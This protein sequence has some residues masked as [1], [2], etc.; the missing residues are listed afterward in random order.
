MAIDV[1]AFAKAIRISVQNPTGTALADATRLLAYCNAAIDRH[2]PG[3]DDAIKDMA[4][5]QLGQ[6]LYDAPV[7]ERARPVT[8]LA[9]SGV[10]AMLAPYRAHRIGIDVDAVVA[11]MPEASGVTREMV[12]SIINATLEGDTFLSAEM[13]RTDIRIHSVVVPWAIEGNSDPLP[14]SKLVNAPTGGMGGGLTAQQVTALIDG[15]VRIVELEEFESALRTSANIIREH[16]I[17]V[18]IAEAAYLLAGNPTWPAAG[19]DREIVAQ[20]RESTTSNN[21]SASFDLATLLRLPAASPAQ[22]LSSSNAIVHTEGGEDYYFARTASNQILFSAGS[23]G[24]YYLTINDREIDL[25]AFARKSSSDDVPDSKIPATIAR[26]SQLGSAVTTLAA[27]AITVDATGFDG[28]LATTD[29]D[30]QK[31]AQKVDDLVLGSSGGGGLDQAAV[32]ARVTAL[33]PSWARS[34]QRFT[35]EQQDVFD[36]FTGDDAW[37]DASSM[38]GKALYPSSNGLTDANID[39]FIINSLLGGDRDAT[40]TTGVSATF[41]QGTAADNVR[42]LV[43]VTDADE[44]AKIAN[45]ELRVVM[46]DSTGAVTRSFTSDTWTTITRHLRGSGRWWYTPE[47]SYA[48]AEVIKVEEYEPLML[49]PARIENFYVPA[50]WARTGN[51]DAIPGSKLGNVRALQQYVTERLDSLRGI[52]IGS[53]TTNTRGALTLFTDP[54]TLASTDH[55]LLL[56]GI[57]WQVALASDGVLA[58]DDDAT[59]ERN[60]AFHEITASD[61]Y[62]A[63]ALNGIKVGEVDVWNVTNA[64]RGTTK[65]GTVS[66]WIAKNAAGNVGFYFD[67]DAD[68]GGVSASGSIQANIEIFSIP[69]GAPAAAASGGG[70]AW[71]RTQIFSGQIA[72][73][74]NFGSADVVT[75][76]VSAL[77][78]DD[79]KF[80][81]VQIS[82]S[83]GSFAHSFLLTVNPR[84]TTLVGS[85]GSLT[86]AIGVWFLRGWSGTDRLVGVRL[87]ATSSSQLS[88]SMTASPSLA[89]NAMSSY[90]FTINKIT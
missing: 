60:I 65:Y 44:S 87:Q 50:P 81:E 17:N 38:V 79:I 74:S 33:V 5:V 86:D 90:N 45:G 13:A 4:I 42:V 27:S 75:A 23:T 53:V 56:V 82:N 31:V 83:S 37:Q 58:I 89:N 62:S 61:N 1:N 77:M 7:A 36:A 18:A 40:E 22:T 67:Y 71:T 15:N 88:F 35:D 25:E 29:N 30:V 10:K 3:L 19:D 63:T 41:M 76:Y 28:N 46:Q 52:A 78:D 84:L 12:M 32:D 49:D 20:F 8:A 2:A 85:V 64:Q 80:I 57:Q 16:L 70:G 9:N 21:L 73:L 68:V 66:F 14:A 59:D 54:L 48:S 11:S 51:T 26:T 43:L 55:G 34:T 39:N 6:Y 47:F 72:N 69:S 24:S